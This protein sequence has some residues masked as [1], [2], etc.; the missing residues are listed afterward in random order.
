MI[1]LPDHPGNE[2]SKTSEISI[3]AYRL[4]REAGRPHGPYIDFWKKATQLVMD[5]RK[6]AED[7]H[8]TKEVSVSGMES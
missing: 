3:V 5:A 2:T 1:T 8:V 4:W 6:A 7:S